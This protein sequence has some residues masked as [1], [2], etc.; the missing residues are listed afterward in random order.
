[1]AREASSCRW[2]RRAAT[3]KPTG[4]IPFARTER[5]PDPLAGVSR[6]T[7][8]PSRAGRAEPARRGAPIRRREGMAQS[9]ASI[10]AL[11]QAPEVDVSL[12]RQL[13]AHL[14]ESA[15]HLREEWVRR[16]TEA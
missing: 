12:L 10:T 8:T 6:S 5:R 9:D 13:V 2:T 15:A 16:I 1:S 14:R 4:P 7:Y 3:M 11:T